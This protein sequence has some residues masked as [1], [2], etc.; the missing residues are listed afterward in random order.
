M[1]INIGNISGTLR[2]GINTSM[3]KH[4]SDPSLGFGIS[5]LTSKDGGNATKMKGAL[6]A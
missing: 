4:Q 5:V 3:Y 1:P 6:V 2:S